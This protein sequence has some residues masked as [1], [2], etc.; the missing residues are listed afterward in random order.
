MIATLHDE[1]TRARATERTGLDEGWVLLCEAAERCRLL[2]KRAAEH[3]ETARKE[4]EE[5]RASVTDE[6]EEV[7]ARA[8][9]TAREILAQ[10]H[11]EATKI[12]SAAHQRIPSTIGPP[13]LALAGE[14]AR[15]AAQHLLDQARTNADGLLSN[16]RQMLEEAEDMEALL[17]SC[18]E[19]ADSLAENLSL[20]R[21]GLLRGRKRFA[22]ANRNYASRRSNFPPLRTGSIGR[23]N[24][25]EQGGNGQPDHHQPGP[26]PGDIAAS[27]V[28]PPGADGPHAEPAAGQPGAGV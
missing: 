4:A 25:R 26:T 22:T 13:N 18:E 3:R 24:P 6:N 2:D 14:E 9:S 8:R 28:H 11:T 20:K 27:R 7:L 12:T 1:V 23:G 17:H 5:I 10:A 15:R 21:L 19:S 16:T